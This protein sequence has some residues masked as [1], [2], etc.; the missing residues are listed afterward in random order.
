LEKTRQPVKTIRR[1]R[2]SPIHLLLALDC[3]TRTTED[4]SEL[5]QNGIL[6]LTRRCSGI[7]MLAAV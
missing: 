5:M 4:I 7:D 6:A 3:V 1:K 2:E